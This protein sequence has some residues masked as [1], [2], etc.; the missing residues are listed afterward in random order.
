M[1][2]RRMSGAREETMHV[3]GLEMIK[4]GLVIE[5]MVPHLRED[6]INIGVL[7]YE[8][9][10]RKEIQNFDECIE[11]L[12]GHFEDEVPGFTKRM[13]ET[14]KLTKEEYGYMLLGFFSIGQTTAMIYTIFSE[15]EEKL[16]GDQA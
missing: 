8:Q 7:I 5:D 4:M 15:V 10:W 13:L 11:G 6:M 1:S 12:M 16:T 3:A 9:E 2:N 14:T